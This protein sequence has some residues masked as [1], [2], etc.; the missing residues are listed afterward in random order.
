MA[1]F[2]IQ[3]KHSKNPVNFIFKMMHVSPHFL[4]NEKLLTTICS[5]FEYFILSKNEIA[6]KNKQ[7]NGQKISAPSPALPC[8]RPVVFPRELCWSIDQRHNQL[9]QR[10][11]LAPRKGH[12]P[13]GDESTQAVKLP[14]S[15]LFHFWCSVFVCP[16]HQQPLFALFSP[17]VLFLKTW[18]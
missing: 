13:A 6:P 11:K 14:V 18:T 16:L 15:S 1:K 4:K 12:I 3:F 17:I 2:S 7:L 8:F 5:F 9:E 10:Q